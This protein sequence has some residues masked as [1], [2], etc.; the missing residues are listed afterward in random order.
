MKKN[1]VIRNW[2]LPSIV[3]HVNI[4]TICSARRSRSRRGWTASAQGC[5]HTGLQSCNNKINWMRRSQIWGLT[6]WSL[7][8]TLTPAKEWQRETETE[9]LIA[10]SLGFPIDELLPVDANPAILAVTAAVSLQ[11]GGACSGHLS[12]PMLASSSSPGLR[13]R[14]SAAPAAGCRGEPPREH[15]PGSVNAT[16][17]S[18]D[19]HGRRLRRDLRRA[20]DSDP[21]D[22]TSAV[23]GSRG[24]VV[25]WSAGSGERLETH[26]PRSGSGARGL[27]RP[28]RE[29]RRGQRRGG[30]GCAE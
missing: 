30:G 12:S 14:L 4:H 3:F 1:K 6:C 11:V 19:G 21:C 18:S 10:L 16:R 24:G 23:P 15:V 29:R 17:L 20:A 26:E 13:C 27:R 2:Y 8:L 25:G 9:A 22:W 28:G 5:H 7:N